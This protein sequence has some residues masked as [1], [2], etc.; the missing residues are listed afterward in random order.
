VAVAFDEAGDRQL[1][2]EIDD[3]GVRPDHRLDLGRRAE[4][5][6]PVLGDRDRLH[7]RP[8]VVHG[9]DPP[10][11]EH[12]IGRRSHGGAAALHLGR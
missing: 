4:R 6:N 11:G 12:E 1:S 5:L 8:P 2:L 10:V 7:L 3:L 9:D